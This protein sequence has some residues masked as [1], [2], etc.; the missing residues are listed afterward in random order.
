M[1]S[2][3]RTV[4]V[5]YPEK[6]RIQVLFGAR[7]LPVKLVS[8]RCPCAGFAGTS[9]CQSL[10]QAI[11][12]LIWIRLTF[13]Q[14]ILLSAGTPGHRVVSH[15]PEQS[16]LWFRLSVKQAIFFVWVQSWKYCLGASLITSTIRSCNFS[17]DSSFRAM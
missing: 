12:L 15:F 10:P 3:A 13:K 5:W 6:P 7:W 9:R 1:G 4:S 11:L 17:H 14:A 8:L 2:F 16:Y